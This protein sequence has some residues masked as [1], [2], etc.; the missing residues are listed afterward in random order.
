TP[1]RESIK[2]GLQLGAALRHMV[3]N[4]SVASPSC[5]TVDNAV[6]FQFFE[7]RRQDIGG[8]TR[9]AA[10]QIR[11]SSRPHEQIAQNQQRPPLHE[12]LS[13]TSHTTVLPVIAFTHLPP[14]YLDSEV[15]L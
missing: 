8:N 4:G 7:P 1:S 5:R 12:C 10:Q 11:I 6:L 2:D 3:D 9:K 14:V 15:Y 13:N